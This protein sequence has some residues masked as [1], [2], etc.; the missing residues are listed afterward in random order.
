MDL[1]FTAQ[2]AAE[3]LKILSPLIII[4]SVYIFTKTDL[5]KVVKSG[6]VFALA[7]IIAVLSAY[8]EGS[9]QANFWSNLTE[10]YTL[11]QIGYW[12]IMKAAGLE[13][14][15]APKEALATK[16]GASIDK[17][18]EQLTTA[19]AISILDVEQ[20]PAL[21]VTATVVNQQGDIV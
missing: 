19:E 7:G 12:A 18:V 11:S 3:L 13:R 20:P 16:A 15:A 5:D 1:T 21:D 17:K 2:N 10:I 14:L 6:I 9:L 8:A 4:A